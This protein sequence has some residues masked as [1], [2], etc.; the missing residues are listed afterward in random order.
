MSFYCVIRAFNVDQLDV[1][2]TGPNRSFTGPFGL[3]ML[4]SLMFSILSRI[5]DLLHHL[6]FLSG[7][8]QRLIENALKKALLI[9][10]LPGVHDFLRSESATGH[11][12]AVSLQ[13]VFATPSSFLLV[14]LAFSPC[15]DANGRI[16]FL[17]TRSSGCMTLRLPRTNQMWNGGSIEL[18][19][20][21]GY[22]TAV[23]AKLLPIVGETFLFNSHRRCQCK[24]QFCSSD[25]WAIGCAM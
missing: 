22:W 19:V 2:Y 23:G 12:F 5:G 1:I 15:P 16:D 20:T 7:L 25:L 6:G 8:L 17:T 13:H 18:Q 14:P 11:Y 10:P 4:T 3:L 9:I 21:E 24:N